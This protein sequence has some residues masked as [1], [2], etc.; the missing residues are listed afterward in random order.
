MKRILITFLALLSMYTVG[1]SARD[2][3]PHQWTKM[4]MDD[5]DPSPYQWDGPCGIVS[6]I[7]EAGYVHCSAT[8]KVPIPENNIPKIVHVDVKFIGTPAKQGRPCYDGTWKTSFSSN[9]G[10]TPDGRPL[11]YAGIGSRTASLSVDFGN[12]EGANQEVLRRIA[13]DVMRKFELYA[14]PCVPNRQSGETRAGDAASSTTGSSATELPDA[15]DLIPDPAMPQGDDLGALGQSDPCQD[16]HT[17]YPG[18]TGECRSGRDGS[19]ETLPEEGT[20]TPPPE[21]LYKLGA[22]YWAGDGVPKNPVRARN[23]LHQAAEMGHALAQTWYGRALINGV[24]GERDAPEGFR[25]LLRGAEQDEADSQH[26][27][28]MAYFY[29]WGTAVDMHK[30]CEWQRKAAAQG[31]AWGVYMAGN[32]DFDGDDGPKNPGKGVSAFQRVLEMSDPAAAAA[33]RNMLGWAYQNGLGVEKDLGR[34]A[35]YYRQSAE[36]GNVRGQFNYG[37]VLE[38]GMGIERNDTES[39]RWYRLAEQNG[40]Q[41][42]TAKVKELSK[43]L[44]NR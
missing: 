42:A 38:H 15:A 6:E 10:T 7:P 43:L 33:A 39:L 3:I 30:G 2:P 14:W 44:E 25:W 23:L 28:G 37:Y 12:I 11:L 24:G 5:V 20:R 19:T 1:W 26:N 40:N 31:H 32:C 18:L 17:A 13:R 36:E 29:G 9:L 41:A 34:A 22:A 35:E 4:A 27:L 8:L 16:S 21:T